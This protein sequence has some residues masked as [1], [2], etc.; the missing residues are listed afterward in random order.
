MYLTTTIPYILYIVNV[1][2]RFMNYAKESHFK[3]VKKVLRYVKGTLNYGIKFHRSKNFKLQDYSD[4]DWLGFL[5]DM[6]S[7]SDYYFSY[8]SGIFSWSSK[9]KSWHNQQLNQSLLQ[10]QQLLIMSCG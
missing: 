4:S 9:K 7:T 5:D 10:P 6:K 2:S 8:G 1:L 3:E